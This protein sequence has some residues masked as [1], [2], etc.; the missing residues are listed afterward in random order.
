MARYVR[1]YGYYDLFLIH[2]EGDV[3]YTVK[4]EADYG[5]N[6][7]NGKYADSGLGRL[8]R[9]ILPSGLLIFEPYPPS[10]GNPSAFIA[11]PVVHNGDVQLVVALQLSLDAINEVM[12]ERFGMGK[13]G[14]TYVVGSDKLLHSDSFLDPE[15]Y[16]VT[17]SFA[18]PEKGR[19]D[20]L[21]SRE[22][23]GKKTG[24]QL[25][26]QDSTFNLYAVESVGYDVCADRR[27]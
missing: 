21:A 12:Q 26:W 11:L 27:D 9:K 2:P 20:T 22:A 13:T 8:V 7:L 25:H 24:R 3:F 10:D 1:K 15:N 23:L 17:A 16:S 14:E 5:T 18:N 19:I 6:M 4:H